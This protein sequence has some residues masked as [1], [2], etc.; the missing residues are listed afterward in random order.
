MSQH[1]SLTVIDGMQSCVPL[2]AALAHPPAPHLAPHHAGC[3]HI[4]PHHAPYRSP[5]CLW[6]KR[7][8]IF[9]FALLVCLSRAYYILANEI[10]I[11]TRKQGCSS[12]GGGEC[13][14]SSNPIYLSIH[15]S[16]YL[17]IYL[18][19]CTNTTNVCGAARIILLSVNASSDDPNQLNVF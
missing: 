12:R 16:I 6:K 8:V 1:Q 13:S 15:P 11:F 4:D 14:G 5:S 10:S 7:S 3:G 18:A 9:H 17:S 19:V 2:P